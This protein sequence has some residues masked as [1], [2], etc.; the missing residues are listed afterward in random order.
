[1]AT[2]LVSGALV[3]SAA[4][5]SAGVRPK[6][7]VMDAQILTPHQLMGQITAAD[8]LRADLMRSGAEV[9][10]TNARL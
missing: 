10:V 8:A 5:A 7:P 3:M 1:V 2:A 6:P 4:P 9:A